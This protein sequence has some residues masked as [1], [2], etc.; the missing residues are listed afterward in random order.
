LLLLGY[1]LACIIHPPL[2]IFFDRNPQ[3]VRVTETGFEALNADSTK[4]WTTDYNCV[5]KPAESYWKVGDLDDDGYNE[6]AVMPKAV[7]TSTCECNAR[8]YVY[9]D[10]G[11]LLFDRQGAI[12][13]EYPGDFNLQQPY[14]PSPI[15]FLHIAQEPVILT[16]AYRSNPA[17]IH[18]R[19]WTST[20]DSLG[21]YINAGHSGTHGECFSTAGQFGLSFLS[22]NNRMDCACLFILAHDSSYGASPPYND[23]H[24]DLSRVKH[25]NQIRYVL[26]PRTNLNIKAM[27]I[28]N[29]PWKIV[30]ES[31]SVL[32]ADIEELS[33]HRAEVSYY[34]NRD[35]RVFHVT[36]SDEF[37]NER[38]ILIADGKLQRSDALTAEQIRDAV[39][40]WIDSAWVTEGELRTQEINRD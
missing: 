16:R 15:D 39:T 7:E 1:L 23:P 25:S 13:G 26:F 32:R 20:G 24:Y 22:Y 4:I 35:L 29:F 12:F 10:N 6:V 2:W 3:Y 27:A 34:F 30:A 11:K 36:P 33:L 17:R 8:L 31:D 14:S 5:L 19:F 38:K 37:I 21:W 40:Y 28:Y 18:L 9:S